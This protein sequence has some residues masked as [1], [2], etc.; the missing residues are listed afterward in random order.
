[1][2]DFTAR[3]V[4]IA[5]EDFFLRWIGPIDISAGN[6]EC[7]TERVGRLHE[8]KVDHVASCEA[9]TANT[10]FAWFRPINHLVNGVDIDGVWRR[11]ARAHRCKSCLVRFSF[12]DLLFLAVLVFW[13]V[14][15]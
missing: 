1:M 4:K 11:K 15:Q 8:G 14:V 2:N 13:K 7:D 12:E 5:P 10:S 6:I 3:T 9:G